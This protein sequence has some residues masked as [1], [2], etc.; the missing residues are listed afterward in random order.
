MQTNSNSHFGCVSI[1]LCNLSMLFIGL[2]LTGYIDWE[3]GWVLCPIWIYA[4]RDLISTI[5]VEY[6]KWKAKH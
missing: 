5:I 3:W 2:K 1:F 4:G 6:F